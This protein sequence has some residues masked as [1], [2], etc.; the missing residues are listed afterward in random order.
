[1]IDSYSCLKQDAERVYTEINKLPIGES[2]Y[3]EIR[4]AKPSL[5]RFK[6]AARFIYLN[7]F[8]FNGLY[9]T[10]RAGIF[11]VPYGGGDGRSG[12]L[13]S[14]EGLRKCAALLENSDLVSGDFERCLSLA[15]EGDF[16]YIDPPYAVT[17]RRVFS[18]YHG[19]TFTSKDIAR[20]RGILYELNQRGCR[21]LLSYAASPEGEALSRGFIKTTLKVQRNISGFVSGRALSEEII[22]SNFI[23]TNEH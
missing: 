15:K 13:P 23:P 5:N 20:L 7:R 10:N 2:A 19:E 8:C 17:S 21:F 16:A 12:S 22:V 9:R 14:L 11:N 6:N 3:Y 18:E 1:L 4:K